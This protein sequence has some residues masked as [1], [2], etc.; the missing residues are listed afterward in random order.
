MS[1]PNETKAVVDFL[2][3]G[4]EDTSCPTSHQST[5]LFSFVPDPLGLSDL[6][7]QVDKEVVLQIG[8]ELVL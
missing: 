3:I 2:P 6:T 1:N 4:K 8:S 7:I 5:H